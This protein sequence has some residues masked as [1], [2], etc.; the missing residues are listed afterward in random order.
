MSRDK[1]IPPTP[2]ITTD[3]PFQWRLRLGACTRRREHATHPRTAASS[4]VFPMDISRERKGYPWLPHQVRT[5]VL[6][7][8]AGWPDLPQPL[9][10]PT[11]V[12]LILLL[13]LESDFWLRPVSRCLPQQMINTCKLKCVLLAQVWLIWLLATHLSDEKTDEP[14]NRAFWNHIGF[15]LNWYYCDASI[16]NI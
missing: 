8:L 2:T 9:P 13:H 5:H 16:L 3:R 10:T 7:T 12:L 14:L 4:W 6:E 15:K 1:S 11:P